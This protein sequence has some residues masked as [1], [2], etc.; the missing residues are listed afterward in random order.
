MQYK[1]QQPDSIRP[2]VWIGLIAVVLAGIVSGC[3]HQRPARFI[4]GVNDVTLRHKSRDAKAQRID[5]WPCLRVDAVI[6]QHLDYA[7][8]SDDLADARTEALAFLDEAHALAIK[9]TMNEMDRLGPDGWDELSTAYLN[10]PIKAD[11]QVRE[12]LKDLFITDTQERYLFLRRRVELAKTADEVHDVLGPV[13]K[14]IEK[15]VK[16][17]GRLTRTLSWALF[18]IP[19]TLA[20]LDIQSHEYRGDLDT[21]FDAAVRYLPDP[22]LSTTP[23]GISPGEWEQLLAFAPVIV[24]ERPKEITYERSVDRIGRVV[25]PDE[26]SIEIDPS[27][28]TVYAYTRHIRID[29]RPHTQLTY[30]YWYPSHPALKHNDPEAGHTEGLTLRLT[31]DERNEPI[32]F[33][34]LYNCGCYHRLYPSADLEAAALQTFGKPQKGKQFAIERRVPW[35]F[36]TIVPKLVQVQGR[37]DRPVIR[38]R[39][40]WHGIVNVAMDEQGHEAEVVDDARYTLRPYDELERLTTPDG[41]I[42]SMFYD[43]GLVKGAQRLEGVFFTPAGLLSSGQPRQRGTQ[44]IHWDHY[45]FDDPELLHRLLRLPD[46]SSNSQSVATWT[47]HP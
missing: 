33:E 14:A 7:L 8:A 12:K 10:P 6:R 46:T 20:I 1:K 28:P 5:D 17:Q 9:S 36:D 23:Q 32:T 42:V 18:A 34:T 24:Q 29:G 11:G 26:D 43:N 2:A 13:V 15:P 45:D 16:L 31:L 27:D 47:G 41:Q 19:S 38:N 44:M 22:A 35:K 40:G 39:A 4:D 21:P 3:A 30:T 37:G 25:A